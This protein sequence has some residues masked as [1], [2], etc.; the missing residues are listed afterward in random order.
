MPAPTAQGSIFSLFRATA[1]PAK[2]ASF[3]AG[4]NTSA[5]PEPTP[6]VKLPSV[7]DKMRSL[8]SSVTDRELIET[9][10]IKNLISSYFGNCVN[11]SNF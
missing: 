9:E 11:L 3:P 1:E 6:T 2:I 10:I 5:G 7:P 8:Q 4:H